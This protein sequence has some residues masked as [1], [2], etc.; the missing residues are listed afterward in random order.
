MADYRFNFE[1]L[2]SQPEEEEEPSFTITNPFFSQYN[3]YLNLSQKEEKKEEKKEELEELE[4]NE[5]RSEVQKE[6]GDSEGVDGKVEEK[7]DG[8]NG[9][10][11][12]GNMNESPNRIGFENVNEKENESKNENGY[13]IGENDRVIIKINGNETKNKNENENE[14]NL[15]EENLIGIEDQIFQ[16]E[17]M[18][19]ESQQQQLSDKLMINDNNN[20]EDQHD[21]LNGFEN[22]IQNED[23]E[24]ED[25]EFQFSDLESHHSD[26]L[27]AP[28]SPGLPFLES[29]GTLSRSVSSTSIDSS[30]FFT[31]SDFEKYS[32]SK[33]KSLQMKDIIELVINYLIFTHLQ[34]KKPKQKKN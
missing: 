4:N 18:N 25:H 11:E 21:I 27:P 33:N 12:L 19:D 28:L 15:G 5:N 34:M 24:M 17:E 10:E 22:E 2:K 1:S 8:K 29:K 32:I 13:A 3:P 9:E 30:V 7:I 14:M 16:E 23:E 26:T 6:K 20:N 31:K